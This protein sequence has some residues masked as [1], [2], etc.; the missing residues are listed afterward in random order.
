MDEA[1][2]SKN[3]YAKENNTNDPAFPWDKVTVGEL[4]TPQISQERIVLNQ[5]NTEIGDR[6]LGMRQNVSSIG[7]VKHI[8]LK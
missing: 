3:L 7:K 2:S 5:S 6:K 8:P 1:T 4:N